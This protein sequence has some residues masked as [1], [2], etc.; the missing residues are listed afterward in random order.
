[1]I[2]LI[3]LYKYYILMASTRNSNTKCN[4]KLEEKQNRIFMD[5]G[6]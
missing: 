1:M 4:Y 2:F 6:I 3:L 5:Y